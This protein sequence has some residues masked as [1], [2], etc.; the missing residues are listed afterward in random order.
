M[1]QSLFGDEHST[2]FIVA[3]S[4]SLPDL[5]SIIHTDAEITPPLFFVFAWLSAKISSAPEWLRLP[6]FVAGLSLIPLVY[7]TG[8]R[9]IG[10]P[11]ALTAAALTALS[12]FMIYYSSEAR[13][14]GLMITL[15]ALS[16][17]AM[18][19]GLEDRRA[20]WWVLY[21]VA[22]CGAVYS[23]YTSVFV[24]GAQLLWLLIVHREAW[25]PAV[26]ANVGAVLGFAPWLS[27]VRGDLN[28]PTT[29]ILSSLQ[30]LT[31][32]RVRESIMDWAVG[33]PYPIIGLRELPGVPALVLLAVALAGAAVGL[34]IRFARHPLHPRQFPPGVV[35]VVLLALATPVGEAMVS[36]L[37]ENDLLGARN[38][39]ASWPGFALAT[40]ALLWAP[41]GRAGMTTAALAIVAFGIGAVKMTQP[42]YGRPQVE[43][44][45][46]FA[47]RSAGARGVI[48]DDTSGDST[49]PAGV[50][51]PAEYLLRPEYLLRR[52]RRLFTLGRQRVRYD[53]FRPIAPPP[54]PSTVVPIAFDAARGER[55]AFMLRGV[56]A[57]DLR[58]RTDPVSKA[59]LASIPQGYRPTAERRYPGLLPVWVIVY[60]RH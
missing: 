56:Q 4:G 37:G 27:G 10:R 6:S 42:D 14:Y 3:R 30:P 47:E 45:V 44:A 46:R 1:Q 39:N 25:R 19:K 31:A 49:V 5:I 48:V 13:S 9:T 41:G 18:L 12:P 36:L 11:A 60:G 54:D 17:F 16:T 43:E 23:H 40:A 52:P 7:L 38:L 28:S 33:F 20:R 22:S 8:L 53:P 50:P 29:H 59:I 2:R 58:A 24:L 15:V 26:V 32:E 57:R 51:S 35:L 55:V 34:L 21:G